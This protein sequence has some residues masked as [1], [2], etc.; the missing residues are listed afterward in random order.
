MKLI[1]IYLFNRKH[2]HEWWKVNP[3]DKKWENKIKHNKFYKN[4]TN[5]LKQTVTYKTK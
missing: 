3:N 5:V 1:Y 4:N 2:M